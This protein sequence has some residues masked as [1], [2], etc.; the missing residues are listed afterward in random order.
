VLQ[1]IASKVAEVATL[2]DDDGILMRFMNS[3]LEGNGLRWVR[4][5][6]G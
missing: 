2:F 4:L 5:W 3:N 1:L 6:G